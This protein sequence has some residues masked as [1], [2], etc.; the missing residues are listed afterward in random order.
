MKRILTLAVAAALLLAA[1]AQASDGLDRYATDTWRSFETMVDPGT[2][3]PSDNVDAD[4]VRSGYTSPT[5]V[6]AYLWSTIGARDMGI[7]SSPE[8]KA[9]M[10]K[11]LDTLEGLERDERSGQFFNWYDPKTGDRLTTWPENGDHV[12]PFLSSV[13]NGGL[14]AGL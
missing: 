1:P 7:I 2:G 4:G 10:R 13:E 9:R 12:Y 14:G 11:T 6:G 8:A 5:N 3:L